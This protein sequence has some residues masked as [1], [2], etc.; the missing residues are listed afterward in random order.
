MG[1]KKPVQI[2]GQRFN[3]V[4]EATYY[5]R[6][7]LYDDAR[8]AESQAFLIDLLRHH[9]ESDEKIGAGVALIK[10]GKGEYGTT[11]FF[12]KRTD[13]T[14]IDFSFMSCLREAAKAEHLA[15]VE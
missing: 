1:K 13:G 3:S 14:W 15:A 5:V 7:I 12:A 6:G 11:C 8:V 10:A 2:G 9:P 4:A